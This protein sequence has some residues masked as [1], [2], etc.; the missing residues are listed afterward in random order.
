MASKIVFSNLS[1]SDDYTILLNGQEAG[2][3][4]P[5]KTMTIEVEKGKYDLDVKGNNEEGLP[6]MCRPV[7]ITM[8]DNK[9]FHLQL[10]ALHFAIGIYDEKGT[11]LNDHQGVL[12]GYIADGVHID[13]PR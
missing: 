11:Q 10:V 7:Q 13:N 1:R 6:S 2:K 3:V 12:C 4:L 8:A 9:T 5:L